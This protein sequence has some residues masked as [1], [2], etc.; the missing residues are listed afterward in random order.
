[1]TKRLY[2]VLATLLLISSLVGAGFLAATGSAAALDDDETHADLEIQQP[3][4]VDDDVSL[5]TTGNYTTY[6]LEGSSHD[7]AFG[8]LDENASVIDYGVEEDEGSL[9]EH[10]TFDGYQFDAESDGTYHVYFVVEDEQTVTEGN[11]TTTETVRERHVAQLAV[12]GTDT[13]YV[14]STQLEEYQNAAAKWFDWESDI[15]AI[16]GPNVDVDQQ[17]DIAGELL[18]LRHNPTAALTGDFL[19][20]FLMLFITASGFMVLLLFGAYHLLTTRSLR[21]RTNEREELEAEEA[22]LEEKII[23]LEDKKRNQVLVNTTLVDI[24]EDEWSGR[25]MHEDLGED[26]MTA[27][28]NLAQLI[29]ARNLL[30]DRLLAMGTEGY[31]AAVQT[32]D[33]GTY[34]HARLIHPDDEPELAD[35]ET[36]VTPDDSETATDVAAV[37]NTDDQ[38]LYEYDLTQFDGRL[39]DMGPELETPDSVADL[40]ERI[41]ADLRRFQGDEVTYAKCL[42]EFVEHVRDHQFTDAHGSPKQLRYV[43]SSWLKTA[44]I[45]RD[46]FGLPTSDMQAEYLEKLLQDRDPTEDAELEIENQRKGVSSANAAD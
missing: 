22:E 19:G 36:L 2:S 44:Q 1:M 16:A 34:T 10:T 12:S 27:W 5:D 38:H 15:E 30:H 9:S 43:L 13:A 46:I 3:H 17:T 31:Q 33:D 32:A 40:V 28:L 7:I 6:E 8:G 14:S 24:L 25:A 21:K 23:E 20:V 26:A 18:N 4:Y 29:D 45:N 42:R 41:D 37:I 35:G 11:E 39:A